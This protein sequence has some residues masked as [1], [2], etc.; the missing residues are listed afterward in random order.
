MGFDPLTL[1]TISVTALVSMGGLLVILSFH[2]R[3]AIALRWWGAT[4]LL[5]AS[6]IVLLLSSPND[7]KTLSRVLGSA[8]FLV[9]YGVMFAAC[10][11]FN[12]RRVYWPPI[13]LAPV[14]WLALCWTANPSIPVRVGVISGMIACFCMA[15]A[16]EL[17]FGDRSAIPG[18]NGAAVVLVLHGLFYLSRSVLQPILMPGKPWIETVASPWGAVLGTETLAFVFFFGFLTIAMTRERTAQRLRKASL[19]D[20]LTGI[21]N[22]RALIQSGR[23]LIERCG[24]RGHGM[25]C[26]LF[27][28][29]HFKTVN[30]THGHDA[31]DRLLV[32]FAT[33]AVESLP[34]NCLFCRIGGEEFAALLPDTDGAEARA[35]AETIRARF[36]HSVIAGRNGPITATVSAGISVTAPL[37]AGIEAL[38]SRADVSLYSAK[39]R[40]RNCVEDDR[41]PIIEAAAAQPASLVDMII[42]RPM[43][44]EG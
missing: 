25:A 1:L 35:L 36:E 43:L 27:D 19:E 4:F 9:A 7:Y 21:G 11:L 31:G 18:R 37:D 38:L 30:D 24:V 29:D 12:R 10:C 23:A 34:L 40:G 2:E 17:R 33:L 26:I 14:L 42:D 44:G 16:A 20:V 41:A 39:A 22:R 13:G 6:G 8:V 28:L 5:G 3:E 32:R 15:C